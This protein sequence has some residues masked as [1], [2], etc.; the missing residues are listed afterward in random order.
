MIVTLRE[1]PKLILFATMLIKNQPF[2]YS[3]DGPI[4]HCHRK[5]GWENSFSNLRQFSRI[6]SKWRKTH[7]CDFIRSA[8]HTTNRVVIFQVATWANNGDAVFIREYTLIRRDHL[9]EEPLHDAGQKPEDT[10][11]A[12][13]IKTQRWLFLITA[14]NL[15]PAFLFFLWR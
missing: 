15:L 2:L 11:S 5:G 7:E 4:C 8:L 6:S 12:W 3:W 10:V 1:P 9:P 14:I 13:E